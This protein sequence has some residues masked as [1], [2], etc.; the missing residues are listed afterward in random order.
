MET[1]KHKR[2]ALVLKDTSQGFFSRFLEKIT[3]AYS[4]GS[5]VLAVIK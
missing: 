3:A 5:Q 2:P 1:L 4:P